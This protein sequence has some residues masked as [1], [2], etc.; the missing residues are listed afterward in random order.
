MY[1][2]HGHDSEQALSSSPPAGCSEPRSRQ[3]G[4]RR[5]GRSGGGQN[6]DG[7]WAWGKVRGLSSDCELAAARLR[8]LNSDSELATP[9][10]R[11]AS[12]DCELAAARLRPLNSDSELATPKF[13]G[14][15]SDCELASAKLRG[16]NSDCELTTRSGLGAV[17][18]MPSVAPAAIP[19]GWRRW[20]HPLPTRMLRHCGRLTIRWCWRRGGKVVWLRC[21]RW[22]MPVAAQRGYF[23]NGSRDCLS[24]ANQASSAL[25]TSPLTSVRR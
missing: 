10:F 25:T 2:L 20:T 22:W 8:P 19:M 6:S 3:D 13:Q 1:R 18:P 12:S 21:N 17:W 24:L 7:E 14:A 11:G 15:N 9:K 5:G 4:F 16:A 23:G